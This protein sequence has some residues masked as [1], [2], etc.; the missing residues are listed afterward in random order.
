M[1]YK[2]LDALEVSPVIAAVKDDE[3]VDACLKSDLIHGLAS[4][5]I[6]ADFIKK[7]TEAD[8][9]ISTKPTIIHRAKELGMLTVLRV[10][11]IDSMAYE[12]VKTQVMAAK[13]DVVEVLPGMMPKVIGK[14]C[15]DL[16][17]PVIAGG[18]IREKEDV[19]ALLKAG[20]TSVSSTNPEIWF[21]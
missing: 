1:N 18:M 5:N 21:E 16:P 2:F 3:G 13:P 17:V 19:M 12:N 11:L 15:K 9:V 4:K 7:Y 14:I 20:V 8:G 10:F 6:A